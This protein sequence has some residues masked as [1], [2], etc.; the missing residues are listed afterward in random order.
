MANPFDKFS[1]TELDTLERSLDFRLTSM[2]E[3]IGSLEKITK[4][5]KEKE[6]Y[7]QHL[8]DSHFEV[9]NVKIVLLMRQRYLE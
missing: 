6:K 7:Y 9:S 2:L 4:K 8:T 3:R 1:Y 5:E